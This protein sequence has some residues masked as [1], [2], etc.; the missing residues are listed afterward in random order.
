MACCPHKS[1][2]ATD[3]YVL[4]KPPISTR[5]SPALS[6]ATTACLP[7]SRVRVSRSSCFCFHDIFLLFCFASFSYIHVVGVY[8][9]LATTFFNEFSYIV[10]ITM[11]W[12]C[13]KLI[14][15]CI[16]FFTYTFLFVVGI[17]GKYNFS[18]TFLC[19]L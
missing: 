14:W 7:L 1:E 15:N 13:V 2:P 16:V 6:Q 5:W 10:Y 19:L 3:N 17:Y 4:S 9:V 12:K 18:V 11:F 8:T